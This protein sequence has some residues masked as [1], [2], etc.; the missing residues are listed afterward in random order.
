LRRLTRG[1]AGTVID[2]R[3]LPLAPGEE[4]R[5]EEALGEGEVRAELDSLGP[6]VIQETAYPGVWFVT[7]RNTENE[8]VARFIEVSLIPEILNAQ[9]P[10]IETGLRQ[11]TERL[12]DP[13]AG[14][15]CVSGEEGDAGDGRHT[16]NGDSGDTTSSDT[17]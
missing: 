7:H 10:D 15:R 8:I 16:T 5:I 13:A 12:G 2:L 9:L 1:E 14:G 6:T 17:R 3:S 4:A 11:L